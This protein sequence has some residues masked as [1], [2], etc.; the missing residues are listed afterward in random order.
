MSVQFHFR[1]PSRF[2]L[3]GALAGA[4]DLSIAAVCTAAVIG[5]AA[6]VLAAAPERIRGPA[7]QA[8]LVAEL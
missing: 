3:R 2:S 8:A 5:L 4:R 7:R 6:Q 1:G